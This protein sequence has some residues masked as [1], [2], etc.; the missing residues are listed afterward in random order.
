MT[1]AALL[2]ALLAPAAWGAQRPAILVVV[3]Q[4]SPAALDDVPGR[5]LAAYGESPRAGACLASL[6]TAQDVP[7]HG[8]LSPERRL[9]APADGPLAALRA[10]GYRT[11]AFLSGP[12]PAAGWKELGW[13]RFSAG[14]RDAAGEAASWL[15]TRVSTAPVF[16][17]VQLAEV[18]A[19]SAARAVARLRGALAR[20]GLPAPVS[21]A[22][23][24]AF[25]A[26][27]GLGEASLAARWRLECP[28]LRTPPPR[29]AQWR[30]ALP[31]LL[32]CAGL[33]PAA[34]RREPAGETPAAVAYA[35][36]REGP[37]AGLI[38]AAVV[39]DGRWKLG[40]RYGRAPVLFDLESDPAQAA[41]LAA[42]EPARAA[43][44]LGRLV[45]R[46]DAAVADVR[47][48][49]PTPRMPRETVE[50]LRRLGYLAD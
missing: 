44:L 7:V 6:V 3:A 35:V 13:S 47:R 42:R 24:Q 40:W 20:A 45:D 49:R 31:L 34:P 21:L 30:E 18:R 10:G 17:L 22:G 12:E 9:E 1:S 25:S 41:D 11:A 14:S 43:R 37:R 33:A 16:V 4:G 39:T 15:E 26:D 46:L 32:E 48:R 2:V 19:G 23:A 28:A 29:P 38:T 27:Q 5:D 8:S 36:E 50:A